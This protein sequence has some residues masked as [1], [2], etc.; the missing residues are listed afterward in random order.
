MSGG[1]DPYVYPGTDTLSNLADIRDP[2]EL[3][4]F[5]AEATL[6]RSLELLQRPMQGNF[7]AAHLKA[8]HKHLFQDLYPWAGR[9]RTTVLA[10]REFAGGPVT[11]F[12]E[13]HLL[14]HNAEH[15]FNGL[16]QSAILRNLPAYDFAREAAL[17]FAAL[18]TL[19]P[20]REG[21]GRTQRAF[22]QA[23]AQQA[24]HPLYFDTVSRERMVRASILSTQGDSTMM[25]RLFHEIGDPDRV[26]PLRRAIAF[27]E[28]NG[29]KWNDIYIATTTRGQPYSGRLV[30]RDQDA[31]M[32]RTVADQIIIGEQSDIP[33]E[34]RSGDQLSFTAS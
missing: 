34:T 27:L 24:K 22:V 33:P 13:P 32:M 15:I 6:R 21:N 20:F 28:A 8:T 7:D 4:I 2:Q 11:Y 1:S 29:F 14:E 18:N 26:K 31:F 30:G 19:H 25:I 17:L 5:E 9:F 10:K 23:V 3:A 16:H 12:T